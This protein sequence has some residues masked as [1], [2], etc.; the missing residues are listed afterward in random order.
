MSGEGGRAWS[1]TRAAAY[2]SGIG[3]LAAL[4][5]IFGL[6]Q[7]CSAGAPL[8]EIAGAARHG[9]AQF[10]GAAVDLSARR[11]C[12]P[13]MAS[14]GLICRPDLSPAYPREQAGT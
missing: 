13:L 2:G 8:W 6:H 12:A 5:K 14:G 9:R 7:S 10:S 1:L 11:Q 4:F 3:A